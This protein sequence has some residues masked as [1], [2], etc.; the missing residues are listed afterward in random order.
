MREMIR[1]ARGRR[2]FTL[3]EL[4]MVVVII[5]ILAAIAIPKFTS[6]S[7]RAKE[8]EAR[9]LLRQIATLQ[10]R[11]HAREGFYTT[12]MAQLEG[13]PEMTGGKYYDLS[14]VAHATGFCAIATPNAEGTA[15]GL[16]TFSMDGNATLHTSAG[17]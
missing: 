7:K 13:G 17:C 1:P 14:L 16:E 15:H 12:D 5:G 2:G 8:S 11:Y 6:V 3:I 4:M 9:P 10:E